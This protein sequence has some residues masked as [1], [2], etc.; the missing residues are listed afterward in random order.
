[1]QKFS[2]SETIFLNVQKLHVLWQNRVVAPKT[3]K[4]MFGK[5]K[6]KYISN[7]FFNA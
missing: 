6:K 3:P 1:M 2:K 7:Y 4:S 5:I